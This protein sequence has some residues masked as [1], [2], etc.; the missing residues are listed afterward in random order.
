MDNDKRPETGRS[1]A[2]MWVILF[3]VIIVVAGAVYYLFS[4]KA[5]EQTIDSKFAENSSVNTNNDTS[6]D[7]NDWETLINEEIGI[8]LQYPSHWFVGTRVGTDSTEPLM[9]LSSHIEYIDFY[10]NNN[11]D[12]ELPIS[13]FKIKLF[14]DKNLGWNSDTN[15]ALKSESGREALPLVEEEFLTMYDLAAYRAL[16]RADRGQETASADVRNITRTAVE[17]T[18]LRNQDLY[19]LWLEI[20]ANDP[21]ETISVFDQVARTFKVL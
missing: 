21:N 16:R 17:Y 10:I 1:R 6:V 5:S 14:V 18:Y 2:G 8:E 13:G 3:V 15:V 11:T 7:Q 12:I 9:Y 19:R 20:D 4:G